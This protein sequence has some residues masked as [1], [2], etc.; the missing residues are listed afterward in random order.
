[1]NSKDKSPFVLR[2]P[3]LLHQRVGPQLR[4]EAGGEEDRVPGE[5]PS[6][7]H[8]RLPL[9]RA[10]PPPGG[11]QGGQGGRAGHRGE[12]QG[13]EHVRLRHS[14]LRAG[15]RAER[16]RGGPGQ[17]ER[18]HQGAGEEGVL[19]SVRKLMAGPDCPDLIL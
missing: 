11:G 7:P 10:G 6:L 4:R 12:V 2:H 19:L 5:P 13:E 17:D 9:H 14:L 15:G 18:R 1:M 8:R 3:V 16:V